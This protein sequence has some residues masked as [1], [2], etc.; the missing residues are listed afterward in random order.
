[1]QPNPAPEPVIFGEPQ[2]VVIDPNT[3]LPQNVIIIQSPSA[4]PKVI[5]ILIIIFGVL[6]VLGELFNLTGALNTGG[7]FIAFSLVNLAI[8]GGLVYGGI[9]MTQYKKKGVTLSLSLIG[10]A[11]IIGVIALLMM[12]GM[13]DQIIEDENLTDEEADAMKNETGLITGIGMIGIV[14]CNGIC[15]L[16]IAIPLM[17]SNSGLDD[18]KLFG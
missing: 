7:L 2:Q 3:G 12:P 15:G 10:A 13:I 9:L 5:G 4:A 14:V 17:V 11:A 6:S 1:M 18:S 8:N 16:I